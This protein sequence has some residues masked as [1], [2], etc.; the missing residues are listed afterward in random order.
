MSLPSTL[1]KQSC[2]YPSADTKG[3]VPIAVLCDNSPDLD[4]VPSDLSDFCLYGGLYRHVNLV[5][6]P[7]IALEAIHISPVISADGTAQVSVK[8]G[9]YNP[10]SQTTPCTSFGAGVG[11]RRPFDSSVNHKLFSPWAGCI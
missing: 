10:S 3:G 2:S 6:L 9:L 5:Y 7:E 1:L 4:R 11:R 8:A